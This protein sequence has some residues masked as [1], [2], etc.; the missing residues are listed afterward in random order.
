VADK[1]RIRAPKFGG[2]LRRRRGSARSLE[3]VA[4]RV[5]SVLEPFG[6]RFHR[7]QLLKIEQEGAIPHPLVLYALAELYQVAPAA[8][9]NQIAGELG[10]RR[11]LAELPDTPLLSER[12][13][14]LARWF[15]GL[16]A[17]RQDAIVDAL[18]VG[19]DRPSA[20]LRTAAKRGSK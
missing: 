16:P 2:W 1:P 9:L 4:M 12:A 19:S 5:R 15:D 3:S 20:T 14:E 13:L 6:V 8:L 11:E 10:L 7:S 17:T 18:G